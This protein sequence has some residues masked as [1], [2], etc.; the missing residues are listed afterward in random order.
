MSSIANLTRRSTDPKILETGRS[1]L[2]TADRLAKAIGWFS[3]GLGAVQL[4]SPRTVTRHLG[5]NGSEAV[6]RAFG[7]REIGSG[8]LTLSIDKEA[9]L[10]ARLVGDAMDAVALVKAHHPFNPRHRAVSR[11]LVA[12]AGIALIDAIALQS[13]RTRHS[14]KGTPRDYR[15]RSGFPKGIEGARRVANKTDVRREAEPVH[16]HVH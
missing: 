2:G 1:S 16:V 13:V 4:F 5:V 8:I 3:I 6:V 12:V 7:A 9:G 14:R 15:D 11:S 10:F